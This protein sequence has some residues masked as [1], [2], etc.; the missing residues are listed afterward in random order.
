MIDECRKDLK[1]DEYLIINSGNVFDFQS[2]ASTITNRYMMAGLGRIGVDVVGLGAYDLNGENNSLKEIIEKSAVDLVCANIEGYLPYVRYSKGKLKVLVTSIIDTEFAKNSELGIDNVKDPV[3][4]LRQMQKDIKHDIFIV[5]IHASNDREQQLVSQMPGIDLVVNGTRLSVY[6]DKKYINQTPVV[7]NNQRGGMY[8]A[9][10]D[11]LVD[12]TNKKI[13][14]S[15]PTVKRAGVGQ[16][17]EDKDMI[18]LIRAYEGERRQFFGKIRIEHNKKM[19][20]NANN[21]IFLG[22][23]SCEHCH[24]AINNEWEISR[25]GKAIESLIAKHKDYDMQCLPCHVT[26][27]DGKGTVG[28][29]VSMQENG[30]M[31]G[32]QC[33]AC[34]GPGSQHA[35]RP[36][37]FKTKKI[38]ASTCIKC[39]TVDTDPEFNYE[40][41]RLLGTHQVYHDEK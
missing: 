34:H 15:K 35:Q 39:H 3:L 29:F 1:Q 5:I 20:R 11:L 6:D 12:S 37:K 8:V 25:H 30:W 32:V 23:R 4:V 19:Q 9:Y 27:M 18:A 14:V 41:D 40:K 24:S 31:V 22:S 10:V 2:R 38:T 36:K 13:E 28:G 33:E 16:I 26:G 7:Y 17:E 21:G